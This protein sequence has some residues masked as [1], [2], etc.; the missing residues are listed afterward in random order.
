M[1]PDHK[2]REVVER[3]SIVEVVSEYVPLRRSGANYLGLCP[4]HAEKTP[5]FNVNPARE[6]F[7]CFGCG[8]GGNVI[9]FVM[10]IEGLS[11]PESVKLL[12]R[13]TGVDIEE[14]LLTPAEKQ[15]QEEHK[16]FRRIQELAAAYYCGVL[17]RASEAGLAREYLE[18]RNA[19]GQIAET[20]GLGFAPDRRDGLV[21]YLKSQGASLDL[22]LKLGIVRKGDRGWHD[23]FRN[24]LIFPVRSPKGDVIA[25]AGRVLDGSLPK[26]INSPESPLY[27]KSSV[28]FGL[29]LALP[30][31]RT[32]NSVIIV[33]GYFDHLALYRAGVRNVVATC[34]TALTARHAALIKRHCARAFTLFDG[35]SAGQKATIRSMELFLEQKLPAY[36]IDLPAGDDPD[37][38]LD[39]N[40]VEAF[41]SCQKNAKPAFEYFIRYV[42]ASIPADSVD[43]KV[44]IVDELV[45]RFRKI[46]DPLERDLYEKEICRLLGI[47]SH[48]FRKRLGGMDVNS[49]DLTEGGKG[50]TP[51]GDSRQETLLGL[52]CAY[53]EACSEVAKCGVDKL[54]DG[55]YLA[56][57]RFVLDEVAA[58][59][60]LRTLSHVVDKIE[61]EEL[62][63][64]LSRLLVS[65]NHLEGVDWK[66]VFESCRLIRE[67]SALHYGYKD[68]AARLAQL[69]PGC[70][71][72]MSLLQQ[73]ELLRTRK[74]RL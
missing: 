69:E 40:S 14:R 30:A 68:I 13:K 26:Y 41:R 25:F 45:P 31:I 54:F 71:E 5:S 32:E 73:A 1:I 51:P 22:A 50:G 33:E 67:K 42:M 55:Q 56:L 74:S 66:D 15:A 52:I 19:S 49:H 61:S 62:K 4:F 10:K 28:L 6:I 58:N 21:Q 8:V 20:Y 9:S 35:D 12:A 39:A 57:A 34:G 24:R 47:A 27:H 46:A 16:I 70:E 44:R 11:F 29:D 60:Q 48:A 53:P 37:S 72:Y 63:L 38:F 43:S 59:G 3:A 65:D 18:K 2:V 7:H 64:F 17:Q 36:V 23:L